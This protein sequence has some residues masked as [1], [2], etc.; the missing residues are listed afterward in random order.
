MFMIKNTTIIYVIGKMCNVERL[1][2][3]FWKILKDLASCISQNQNWFLPD[4]KK[5]EENI[6]IFLTFLVESWPKIH[7][8]SGT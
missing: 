3:T 6:Y 7:M 5:P 1:Y 2:K 4:V 8:D